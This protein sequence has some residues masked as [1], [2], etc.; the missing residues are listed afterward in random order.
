MN[1]QNLFLNAIENKVR[2]GNEDYQLHFADALAHL[3]T[4]IVKV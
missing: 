1:V 2:L 3:F 4:P